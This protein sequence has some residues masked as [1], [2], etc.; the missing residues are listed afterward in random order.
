MSVDSLPL[1]ELV[2]FRDSAGVTAAPSSRPSPR[3]DTGNVHF[4]GAAFHF[5][6][7]GKY[8]LERVP[9]VLAQVV[10]EIDAEVQNHVAS[11]LGAF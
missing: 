9:C 4:S 5:P 6:L 3:S 7:H 11:F 10:G 1:T 2:S 8:L